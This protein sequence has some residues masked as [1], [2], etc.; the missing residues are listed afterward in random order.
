MH[1]VHVKRKTYNVNVTEKEKINPGENFFDWIFHSIDKRSYRLF[2]FYMLYTINKI[3]PKKLQ[4]TAI[5]LIAEINC[6]MITR[7]TMY[8]PESDVINDMMTVQ[9]VQRFLL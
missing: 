8:V 1:F 7:L 4:L 9:A 6:L 3:F 2:A 5:L